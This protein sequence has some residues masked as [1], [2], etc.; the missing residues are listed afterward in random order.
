M[1]RK[2][3]L[4]NTIEMHCDY[5]MENGNKDQ[6]ERARRELEFSSKPRRGINQLKIAENLMA[7][8]AGTVEHQKRSGYR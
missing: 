2:E 3:Q 8:L 4:R 1:D 6:A 7:A 5:V